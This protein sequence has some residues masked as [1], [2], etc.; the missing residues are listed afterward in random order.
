MG[1]LWFDQQNDLSKGKLNALDFIYLFKVWVSHWNFDHLWWGSLQTSGTICLGFASSL[2]IYNTIWNFIPLYSVILFCIN[3][4][5]L[6]RVLLL[7]SYP[8][9]HLCIFNKFIHFIKVNIV[10]RY[11]PRLPICLQYHM[12]FQYDIVSLRTY[13]LLFSVVCD[14][15]QVFYY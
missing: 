11:P 2:L 14:F 13:G 7:G 9:I 6:H 12:L 4:C 5:V 15:S 1:P 3:L 10:F 8:L